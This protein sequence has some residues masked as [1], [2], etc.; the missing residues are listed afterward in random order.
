MAKDKSILAAPFKAVDPALASLF[1]TSAGPVKAPKKSRYVDLLPQKTREAPKP[2]EEDGGDEEDDDELS[3]A[4]E[5]FEDVS[6]DEEE[7]DNESSNNEDEDEVSEA[8]QPVEDA[9]KKKRKQRDDDEDL[10]AKYFERLAE[11]DDKPTGKRRKDSEGKAVPVEADTTKEDAEMEDADSNS[12]N[13]VPVHESIAADPTVSEIE[14]ANRTVFVS[15]VC[16]EAVTSRTAKKTLLKHMASILDPKADPP[17]KVDSI[18][19]RSTAF[20]SA[21]LPKRAAYIKKEV[22]EATTK[23]TNAY[24]VY[25]TPLAV[26]LAVEKLNGTVVLDRHIRVDSVAH[27]SPVDHRRCVF[28]GNLGFVDDETV[29]NVKTDENG[30]EITEKKK[31]TKQPM[32]IEEGLWRVFGKEAGKVESVRVPRDPATRVGKGFAYVQFYDGNDVEKA[33]LLNEKKFPPMLP[34]ALRVTRCKAPHKTARALEAKEVRQA[35]E[36]KASDKRS[37]KS[38][39]VPKVTPEAQTLAG[40]AGKLLGRAGAAQLVGKGKKGKKGERSGKP[41][42]KSE[43]LEKSGIKPPEDFVFEGRRASEKDGKPKD[44][45]FKGARSSKDKKGYKKPGGKG[46]ARAAKWRAGGGEKKAAK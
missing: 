30:K 2:T 13:E 29:F 24:V 11:E 10:E 5:E 37:G 12:D 45:K 34:R 40:R 35:A 33:I 3:E 28:V 31:R 42:S 9:R 25:S 16:S 20:A 21:A 27:P 17:Q 14:K 15:N 38:A 1:S 19:F 23:S 6:D 8:P 46:A 43:I 7:S 22:K 26:R 4:S 18:R 32:D 44:L 39:Y 36:R 41:I